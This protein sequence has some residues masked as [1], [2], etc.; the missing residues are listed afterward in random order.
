MGL[1]TPPSRSHAGAVPGLN[2]LKGHQARNRACFFCSTHLL[3]P[4]CGCDTAASAGACAQ[5]EGM[6]LDF[7]RSELWIFM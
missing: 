4:E 1:L 3:D 6:D 2:H 5:R 7:L